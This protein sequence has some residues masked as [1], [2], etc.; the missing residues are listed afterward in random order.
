MGKVTGSAE[1]REGRCGAK[2]R[3]QDA[4]CQTRLAE[5]AKRCRR[6]GGAAPQ[7]KAKEIERVETRKN[8]EI[9]RRALPFG[10]PKDVDPLE[11]LLGLISDKA[12]EV[13]W[14]RFKVEE[15]GDEAKVWGPVEHQEGVGPMGAVDMSTVKA[16]PNTWWVMLRSAEDQLAKYVTAALKAGVAERQVR[17]AEGQAA[18]MVGAVQ[19]VI[20]AL[21]L[22]PEQR[23]RAHGLLSIEFRAL[24][25]GAA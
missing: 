23:D 15:L 22:T 18:K 12:Q 20:E 24:E 17:I 3:G 4:Y 8:E 2:L 9:M 1:P 21:E 6:H 19:R 13:E 5:G 16:A 14:L 10:T 25:G 7:A 11:A